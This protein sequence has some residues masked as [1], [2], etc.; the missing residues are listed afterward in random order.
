[1]SETRAIPRT[2]SVVAAAWAIIMSIFQAYNVFAGTAIR[3]MESRVAEVEMSQ[4]VSR[5]Q[6]QRMREDLLEIKATLARIEARP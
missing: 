6:Y 3:T 5:E 1:M 2:W 4:A